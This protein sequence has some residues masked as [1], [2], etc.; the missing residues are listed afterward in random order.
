MG[1]LTDKKLRNKKFRK[2]EEAILDALLIIG[3]IPSVK[4]LIRIAGISRATL[5]RH[6]RT[7]HEIIPDYE[8]YVLNK[9]RN[10]IRRSAK[11]KTLSARIIYERL[12]VFMATHQK[13][14]KLFR[15]NQISLI[16]KLVFATKTKIIS[17]RK[18]QEGEMF[19]IYAKEVVALIENWEKKG[20]KASEISLTVSKIIH[21]TNTAHIRLSPIVAI[22]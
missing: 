8:Y 19:E 21:L 10:T 18:V 3:G 15:I 6:H 13:I 7:V 14:M 16:E 17:T 2:N 5:Y 11:H 20:S 1:R 12:L 22:K 4:Q 9:Y